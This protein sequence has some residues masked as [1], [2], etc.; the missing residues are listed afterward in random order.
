MQLIQFLES[1]SSKEFLNTPRVIL[2]QAREYPIVFLSQFFT[3]LKAQQYVETIACDT[4]VPQEIFAKLE[5][6]FLGL[7]SLY[8]LTGMED[9]DEK[10]KSA[11]VTYL[12]SYTGAHTVFGFI[13]SDSSI[14]EQK[15]LLIISIPD[16]L[17]AAIFQALAV[18]FQKINAQK[19]TLF[20]K[21]LFAHAPTI[22][23]DQ[24]CVAIHYGQLIGKD[25]QL[26]CASW[27]D[28]II[29][30]EKSLFILSQHFFAK[31]AKA[32]LQLWAKVGHEFG[33]PFWVAFWSE[34]VWRASYFIAY[35][36][37]KQFAP[38]KKIS[39]RLPFS[40]M[41]RDWKKVQRE[42]LKNAHAFLYD[43][44]FNLK[45]SNS[46]SISLDLFFAKFFGNQF[47]KQ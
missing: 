35:Q 16:A 10:R 30:P 34:Q 17:D 32:F 23:L 43:F 41:Q 7:S 4:L 19:N 33:L 8:W 29:A 27:L 36:E 38:A 22:T 20:Q 26:F 46:E 6:S 44:D 40:F 47:Q 12:K 45:N 24:C 14:K 37:Q 21:L 2:F 5:M 39:F 28:A 11:L 25:T 15:N 31:D 13:S 42:E 9:L 18:Y 3:V 1:A